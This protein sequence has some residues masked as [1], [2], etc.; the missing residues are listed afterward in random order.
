MH[1]NVTCQNCDMPITGAAEQGS[2]GMCGSAE[3]IRQMLVLLSSV[4]HLGFT[5]IICVCDP[6]LALQL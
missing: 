4:V 3:V 1:G 6:F 5:N 2:R